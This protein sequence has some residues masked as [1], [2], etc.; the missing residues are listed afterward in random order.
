M[1]SRLWLLIWIGLIIVVVL[2]W[3]TFEPHAH[4]ERM[5]WIPF[6][7][8]PVDVGDVIGNLLFFVPYGILIR[9]D[10]PAKRRAMLLA[11][12][13][14]AVLSLAGEFIQVFSNSRF[15]SMTDVACNVIGAC[16]GARWTIHRPVK[17]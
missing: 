1:N 16:I 6:L 12:G 5:E 11:M 17:R 14:A 4:W 9:H 2:P 13:S 7:S 8:R 3:G 10:V 15:P